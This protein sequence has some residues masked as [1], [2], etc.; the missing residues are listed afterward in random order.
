MIQLNLNKKFRSK[1]RLAL[2]G[3]VLTVLIQ[4]TA[5]RAQSAA[6]ITIDGCDTSAY[7]AVSCV[8][9]PT[10][11]A[12]V[13]AQKLESASFS[14]VVDKDKVVADLKV[15]S[16][17]DDATRTDNMLV[18]DFGM[19]RRGQALP[20]LREATE[21]ILGAVPAED[22]V[23]FIAVT[24]KVDLGDTLNPPIND[25]QESDFLLAGQGRNNVINLIRQLSPVPATPLYDALCKA[26]ILTAKRKV[27]TRAVVVLSDG[28]DANASVACKEDDPIDR[29][30]HDRVPVFAIGIGNNINTRFLKRLA[31]QTNGVYLQADNAPA[32]VGKFAEVQQ[33]LKTRYRVGFT[34]PV[35]ADNAAHSVTIKL[36]LPAG[37]ASDT[38]EF[39]VAAAKATLSGLKLGDT[40]IDLA[41]GTVAL[42]ANDATLT[43]AFT[44]HEVARV[45]YELETSKGK[46]T[47]SVDAAPFAYVFSPADFEGVDHA[48][49]KIKAISAPESPATTMESSIVIVPAPPPVAP[50][51]A[52]QPAVTVPVIAI[53][54]IPRETTLARLT[55][56]PLL[57]ATIAL[58]VVILAGLGGLLAVLA[59]RKK[60]ESSGLHAQIYPAPDSSGPSTDYTS[61]QPTSVMADGDRT[62]IL[63]AG[64]QGRTQVFGG[65][66]GGKTMVFTPPKAWLKITSGAQKDRRQELGGV[67]GREVL[68]GRDAS[69]GAPGNLKLTSQFISRRHARIVLEDDKLFLTDEKSASGTKLNDKPVREGERVEINVGDVIHFGDVAAIVE[70]A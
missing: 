35:A 47:K 55:T 28:N 50:T 59:R 43:P 37:Q 60:S 64:A 41:A 68:I 40:P 63:D 49:L 11:G 22:Q 6:L 17:V 31:I 19:T 34:S 56:P 16:F 8:V 9:L 14:A 65:A 45:D 61:Y 21:Q 39:T 58:G 10:E 2:I 25:K 29:A 18:V 4:P 15:A 46:T 67:G 51:E 30:N 26:I 54:P 69:D 62:S 52:A 57:Y 13:P 38:V 24:G 23:G 36:T 33:L 48:T 53:T 66:E 42:P 70:G 44:G 3:L 32:A 20:E 1:T 7:P 5:A 12:G 27:G